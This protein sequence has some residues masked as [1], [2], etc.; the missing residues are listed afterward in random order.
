MKPSKVGVLG[1]TGAVG[2]MF[3]RM[4]EHHPW[5]EVAIVGASEAS[6]GKRYRDAVTWRLDSEMPSGVADL[7]IQ[8]CTPEAF[9]GVDLVFSGLDS[10]VAENTELAFAEAG[11]TVVSNASA[12][13]MHPDIPLVVPEVNGDVLRS[14]S[15]PWSGQLVTNPNCVV[16]PLVMVLKPIVDR[17]GIDSVHVTSMQ[18]LSGAGYPGVSAMDSVG[19]IL[20]FIPGEEPKIETEPLKIL[21]R[22]LAIRSTAVRVP[23]RHGHLLSIHLGFEG[24]TPSVNEVSQLLQTFETP[25]WMKG[26]PS[27]LDKVIKVYDD[28]MHP[29][30]RLV[31]QVGQGMAVHVGRIRGEGPLGISLMALGHN[32][33][34][35]AVGCALLNAEVLALHQS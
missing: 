5:F 6:S 30:P 12:H 7:T 3:C 22:D 9:E 1:A 27:A 2:Q 11:C 25:S 17:F 35:G 31:E 23:V 20:P 10:T 29:Q 34:R 4:L 16:I 18:A 14:L 19:N 13:R 24:A 21:G 33:I 28:P 26:C 15:Q 8:S 32:T